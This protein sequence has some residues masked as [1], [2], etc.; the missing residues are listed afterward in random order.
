MR[1]VLFI[2]PAA[3]LGGAERSLLDLV[4]CMDREK[5]EPLVL[6]LEDGPLALEFNRLNIE[7]VRV[8]LPGVLSRSGD[9]GGLFQL[10][11]IAPALILFILKLKR[12]VSGLKPDIL[13]ANGIKAHLL[14]SF[15]KSRN[16]KLAWHVRDYLGKR[17][18]SRGLI[19][20]RAK[21]CDLAICNSRSVETDF[22]DICPG[23]STTTVYNAVPVGDVPVQPP[24]RLTRV[25]L[26]GT[27]AVWKGHHLF[28]EAIARGQEELRGRGLT[29]QVI[30]GA[31]YKTPGSQVDIREM[32]A[33]SA[34]HG[35]QDMVSFSGF[36]PD[37][38]KLYAN[39]DVLV[40][41]STRPEP[42]GRT[43][44]EAMARGKVVLGPA[45]GGPLEIIE[46]GVTGFHFK[47][48]DPDALAA[49]FMR[50]VDHP[51]IPGLVVAAQR[52][53]RERFSHKTLR[54]RMSEVCVELTS[55]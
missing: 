47:P 45:E 39:V 2:S 18:K 5:I 24:P 31:V 10:L 8:P 43:L 11:C 54:K 50:A 14:G 42:F 29:F 48:R 38:E 36:E 7:A 51:D 44:I 34:G 55:K 13:Y 41:A 12:V 35:I 52:V 49:A 40:N 17:G 4:Q 28:L 32:Q 6:L 15:L 33:F 30:G 16:Q 22:Q 37:L 1:R 25:C 27:Y 21:K 53:V 20:K 26:A 9:S 19:R 23:V 3:D 46:D